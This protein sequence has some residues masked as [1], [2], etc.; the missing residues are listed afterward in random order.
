MRKI[1]VSSTT[2]A[3]GTNVRIAAALAV[4]ATAYFRLQL[5]FFLLTLYLAYLLWSYCWTM[6]SCR[7]AV[8][9]STAV[10]ERIFAGEA[11]DWDIKIS[12]GWIFPLVRCGVSVFLPCHFEI[13]GGV[14]IVSRIISGN[15]DIHVLPGEIFPR[16][17]C[18]TALYAWL[19]EKKEIAVSLRLKAQLRGVYYLPPVHFFAGDPS[20]LFRGVSRMGGEQY[21]YVFPRLK[22]AE[23][24]VKTLTFEENQ[25]E[26]S[27]GPEDRCLI[28]GVRDYQLSDDLKSINW[29]ATA[30][31][32]SLKTNIYQR[33]DAEYCLVVF[34]LS[35]SDQESSNID[36]TRTEDALLEDAISLAAGLALY[37]LEKGAK[38]AFYTNAPLLHWEK[39][40][41]CPPDRMNA[42]MKRTRRIT[43][44]DFAGGEEQAQKILKLCA[45]I[46]ETSRAYSDQQEKLWEKVRQ[47]P[48]NTLVYLLHCHNPSARCFYSPQRL[49]DLASSRVRLLDLPQRG[50]TE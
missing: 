15:E 7:S 19:K 23:E 25:R 29:Y 18:C 3:A 6:M 16:W 50:G 42:Y 38:A 28:R 44:L 34:D 22:S 41:D 10:Q 35:A 8:G 48:A 32:G 5:P 26:D 30:R 12:N 17:N 36:F 33:I 11:F 20:G 31:T 46:D 24:L 49:A 21:I 27:M 47:I 4:M 13:S 14:P 45:E 43:T 1:W 9:E 39:K 40:E 37:H 2:S